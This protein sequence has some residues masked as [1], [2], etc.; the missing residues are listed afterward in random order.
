VY[1]KSALD[2]GYRTLPVAAWA[3]LGEGPKRVLQPTYNQKGDE[4]WMVVWNPQDLNSAIVVVDDKTLALKAV[5]ADPRIIT[6]TR[7]F[8]VAQLKRGG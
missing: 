8:S 3:E 4:V 2:K 7:I 6:P 5:I 1:D